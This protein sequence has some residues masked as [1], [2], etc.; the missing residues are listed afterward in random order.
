M[1]ISIP[2]TIVVLKVIRS[3]VDVA[4]GVRGEAN[5]TKYIALDHILEGSRQ[6]NI[7]PD[8]V[9]FD[10]VASG[11]VVAQATCEVRRNVAQPWC[12]PVLAGDSPSL[13]LAEGR[14]FVS[15]MSASR[16]DHILTVL[17]KRVAGADE[18]TWSVQMP[19]NISQAQIK[20]IFGRYCF[21][22]MS[23]SQSNRRRLFLLGVP[24]TTTLSKWDDSF[25]IR[26]R[27]KA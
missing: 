7:V 18:T 2:K 14:A 3:F 12:V 27:V 13:D 22:P 19:E 8:T 11:T 4:L 21:T 15:Q 20:S 17:E 26:L 24:K 23:L 25:R 16:I 9:T 10:F 6:E 1:S 5:K